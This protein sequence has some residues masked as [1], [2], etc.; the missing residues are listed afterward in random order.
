MWR[1]QNYLWKPNIIKRKFVI[2]FFFVCKLKS[3]I[4]RINKR[5]RMITHR[6]FHGQ[7]QKCHQNKEINTKIVLIKK[8][9]IHYFVVIIF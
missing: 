6:H 3:G 1:R 5:D 8:I 2:T 4:N 7:E 9:K